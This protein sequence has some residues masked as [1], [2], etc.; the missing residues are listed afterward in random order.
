[1]SMRSPGFAL[2][3]GLEMTSGVD[4]SLKSGLRKPF[5]ER[6]AAK[7]YATLEITPMVGLFQ[8]KRVFA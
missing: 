4:V 2:E 7:L 8:Q 3:K 1:M 6:F 5:C